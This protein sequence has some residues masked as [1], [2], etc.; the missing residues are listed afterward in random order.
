MRDGMRKGAGLCSKELEVSPDEAHDDLAENSVVL[1]VDEEV[2]RVR[3]EHRVAR[4]L[5]ELVQPARARI[6]GPHKRVEDRDH[7]VGH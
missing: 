1:E 2:E 7:A 5:G 3:E 6:E 4:V